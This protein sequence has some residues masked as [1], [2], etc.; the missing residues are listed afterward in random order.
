[1]CCQESDIGERICSS[2]DVKARRMGT[3]EGLVAS[4]S[5]NFALVSSKMPLVERVREPKPKPASGCIPASYDPGMTRGLFEALVVGVIIGMSGEE[6][7]STKLRGST[8]IRAW[9]SILLV[10]RRS[11][12]LV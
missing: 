7:R 5:D 4:R 6:D 8:S 10:I 11:V 1:M 2:L 3:S 12:S 9:S